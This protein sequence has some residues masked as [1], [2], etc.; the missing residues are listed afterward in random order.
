MGPARRHR[1][2]KP[3]NDLSLANDGVLPA[4]ILYEVLLRLPANAICRLRLVCRSW[5]SLSSDRTFATAHA[6]RHPLLAGTSDN[7]VR[8][9][10]LFSGDIIRRIVPVARP[11]YGMNSQLDLICVSASNS[12]ERSSLLNLATGEVITTFLPDSPERDTEFMSPFMLGHIPSTGELKVFYSHVR[13]DR[14][15]QLV[16]TC[17]GSVRPGN[18]RNYLYFAQHLVQ[19]K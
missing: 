11:R 4:E 15:G 3:A 1:Q 6:S 19:P 17:Y 10:D 7:E 2:K 8:V 12:R 16:Q 5:R 13:H 18:C 9:V 14:G